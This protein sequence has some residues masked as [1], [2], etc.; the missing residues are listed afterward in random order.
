M[1][2]KDRNTLKSWNK[3]VDK[4]DQDDSS[5]TLRRKRERE[6]INFSK[7]ICLIVD[8]EWWECVSLNQKTTIMYTWSNMRTRSLHY[9]TPLVKFED[10]VKEIRQTTEIDK[11]LYREKTINKILS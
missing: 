6:L 2:Y 1:K 4:L 7:S 8:K 5:R 11:A 3:Q 10:W 9:N